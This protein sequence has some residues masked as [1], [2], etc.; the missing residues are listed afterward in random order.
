MGTIY[1]TALI[2]TGVV[3]ASTSST[4]ASDHLDKPGLSAG[5][6]G[7]I[8]DVYAFPSPERPGHLVVAVTVNPGAFPT[9]RFSDAVDYDLRIRPVESITADGTQLDDSVELRVSCRYSK[10][11]DAVGCV[12]RTGTPQQLAV[13]D[14]DR[15]I[16]TSIRFGEVDGGPEPSLRIFAGSRSDPFFIDSIGAFKTVQSGEWHYTGLA[17][18]LY[19]T[20]ALAIVAEIDL[21]AA[22]GEAYVDSMLGVAA[23]VVRIGGQ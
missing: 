20:N 2:A 1:R 22:M 13:G 10:K 12:S 5:L 23:E 18:P 19:G 14:A 11:T 3:V 15:E 7:D 21:E 8:G 16:A 4:V 6:A 9:T 17:A